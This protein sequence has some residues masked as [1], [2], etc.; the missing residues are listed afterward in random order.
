MNAENVIKLN[1]MKKKHFVKVAQTYAVKN[2]L[3]FM[4]IKA[5]EPYNQTLFESKGAATK[6][7][8]K[9]FEEASKAYLVSGGIAQLPDYRTYNLDDGVGIH[10]EG[11]IILHIW[12]VQRCE[13]QQV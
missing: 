1:K 13:P 7:L 11:I 10:V 3:A 12:E 9:S 5:L 2:K 4:I 8:W 6:A